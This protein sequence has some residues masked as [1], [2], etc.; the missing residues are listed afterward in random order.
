MED[1]EAKA[2]TRLPS[3]RHMDARQ[4]LADT[5]LTKTKER[6]LLVALMTGGKYSEV[7]IR[8]LFISYLQPVKL[9]HS[10]QSRVRTILARSGVYLQEERF[11]PRNRQKR[12]FL[13]LRQIAFLNGEG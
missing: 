4:L 7:R 3:P 9:S 5:R 10:I 11:G 6:I 2:S 13:T 12:V 8:R 1:A